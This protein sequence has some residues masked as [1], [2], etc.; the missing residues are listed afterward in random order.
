MLDPQR[1]NESF[2]QAIVTQP[3]S[4]FYDIRAVRAELNLTVLSLNKSFI[5][6]ADVTAS[7][8]L[9][10]WC[11]GGARA[12]ALHT[13]T[14]NG[15]VPASVCAVSTIS[16]SSRDVKRECFALKPHASAELRHGW[17]GSVCEH[18]SADIRIEPAQ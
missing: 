7:T 14:N 3:G 18:V 16:G 12:V 8:Q 2:E 6:G 11:A 1:F 15:L 4:A 5:P 10:Q 9:D 17:Q 13:I